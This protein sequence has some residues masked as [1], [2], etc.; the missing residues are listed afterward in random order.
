MGVDDIAPVFHLGEMLY[1]ADEA[2]NTYRTW[3]V[4]EVVG[5]FHS[6]TEFCLVAEYEEQI[7]GFLLGTTIIKPHSAWKYGYLIWLGVHPDVQ[8]HG[9]ADKLFQKFKDL[10]LERGIRMLLADTSAENL[11]ALHFFRKQGF[12]HPH[13]HI[14]LTLNLHSEIQRMRKRSAEQPSSRGERKNGHRT[15]DRTEPVEKTETTD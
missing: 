8:R 5:L 7:V 15:A 10:M 14:Y 1:T 12:G 3:D 13:K 11:S 2:P 6:D 4:Y 9:V